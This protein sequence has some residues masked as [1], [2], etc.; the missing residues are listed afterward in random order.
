LKIDGDLEEVEMF[1]MAVFYYTPDRFDRKPA[2]GGKE[3]QGKMMVKNKKKLRGVEEKKK[4][5]D[6]IIACSR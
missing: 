2:V 3:A 5:T 4:K 6:K 1:L